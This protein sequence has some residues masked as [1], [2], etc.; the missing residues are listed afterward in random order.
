[1]NKLSFTELLSERGQQAGLLISPAVT[2]ALEAYFE[3][4]RRWNRR[5]NLTGL[6]LDALTGEGMDRLFVEPLLAARHL[7]AEAASIIDLGSGGGSPAI[8]MALAVPTASMTMVESRTKKSV[9]LRESAR[10][11]GLVAQVITARYEDL[12]SEGTLAEAFDTLTSRALRMTSRDL[13][14][15]QSFVRGGGRVLLFR[16]A[17][18]VDELMIPHSLS[19]L[20]VDPLPG[21]DSQLL[22]LRKHLDR[23]VPRGTSDN[24]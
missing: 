6:D 18:F 20:Q 1:V 24:A 19:V 9:F 22:V 3:L 17:S 13:A 2:T 8:P 7:P 16:S 11:L 21:H 5:I 10:E 12:L 23:S 15:A 4:L 14:Q